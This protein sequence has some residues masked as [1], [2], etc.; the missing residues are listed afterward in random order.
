MIPSFKK[1]V[2]ETEAARLLG[3]SVRTLQNQRYYGKGL[4]FVKLNR[5]IRYKLEDIEAYVAKH[6]VQPYAV[7][8]E[9]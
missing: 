4:P 2:D 7:P 8:C 1:L 5:R 9:A 6:T 3:I